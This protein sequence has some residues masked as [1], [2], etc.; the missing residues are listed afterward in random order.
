[1]KKFL[2]IIFALIIMLF[3]IV[4]AEEIFKIKGVY[5]DTSASVVFINTIGTYQTSIT[6]GIKLVKIPDEHKVYF[7]IASSILISKKQDLFFNSGAIKQIKISQFTTN[8]NIVRVVMYFDDNYNIDTLKIGNINN[9]LVIMTQELSDKFAQFYQNTYRDNEKLTEDYYNPLIIQTESNN[10]QPAVLNS[11]NQYSNKKLVQ[12]QQ[13]FGDSNANNY[14]ELVRSELSNNIHLRSKYYINTVT[15]QNKG[16]LISGYGYPTIQKPFVLTNPTRMVFD[17]V[18]S[19]INQSFNNKEIPLNPNNLSGDKIKIGRFDSNVTRIVVTSENA[20]QYLPIFSSDNQSILITNP[21]NITSNS[22]ANTRTNIIKYKYQKNLST[23][24]FTLTFDNP[25]I[26]GI[27]RNT[28]NLYVYFFNAAQYNETIFQNSINNTPYGNLELALLK[29]IGIRLTLPLN[30]S[31]E[32]NT[33]LSGDGKNFRIRTTNLKAKTKKTAPTVIPTTTKGKTIIIDPG[34][35]G[36]DYGAIR[37]GINEKDINLDVAKQVQN[38]L[39]RK[40]FKVKMT[41]T[42][43]TYVSLEDRCNITNSSNPYLFV[44]IHVNSC[45]GTEPKG[46]ET[47]YYHDNSIELANTIHSKMTKEI[48]T[49]NRG[50]FKSKFYVINHTAVPAVLLEIGFISNDKERAELV[51]KRRQQATAEAIAEGIIEYFNNHK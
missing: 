23:D 37:E 29:N 36:S 9:N 26:W 31:N 51:T 27:K 40:G 32:V 19:N 14:K 1:M 17:L 33:Y 49:P 24:D 7:D 28:D 35:G 16:F 50:L 11:N 45:V 18:N 3:N 34:H 47:H 38:I 22:L 10:P 48:K 5:F 6:N 12:I 43:D 25:V 42:N 8:P 21:A 39:E 4:N 15:P 2:F 41:R 20:K 13:A 44:S 30:S 46:I